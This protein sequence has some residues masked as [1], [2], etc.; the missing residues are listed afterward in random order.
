MTI[1]P[2]TEL[3]G[4]TGVI[5]QGNAKPA[6]KTD[7]KEAFSNATDSIAPVAGSQMIRTEGTG[8]TGKDSDTAKNMMKDTAQN[9]REIRESA[10]ADKADD[11][12][13]G[14]AAVNDQAGE[15]TSVSAEKKA[16]PKQEEALE[17]TA[18]KLIKEA[19]KVLGVSEDELAQLLSELGLTASALLEPSN[20]NLLVANAMGDGDMMSLVTDGALSDAVKQLNELVGNAVAELQEIVPGLDEADLKDL[21]TEALDTVDVARENAESSVSAAVVTEE[22]GDVSR[23]KN[24]TLPK[25]TFLQEE[26]VVQDQGNAIRTEAV[27]KENVSDDHGVMQNASGDDKNDKDQFGDEVRGHESFAEQVRPEGQ[28]VTTEAEAV[29]PETPQTYVTDPQ[30]LL[31]QVQGQLRT[32]VTADVTSIDMTLHPASLGNVA[33]RIASQNGQ[34]TAQFTAQNESVKEVLEG[35]IMILK[36]NLEQQGV[37]VEAVEVTVASHAFEQNLEQGND[38]ES[39]ASEKEREKLRRAT[40]KINLGNSAGEGVEGLED[41]DEV[42]VEMM[43]ADGQ[44]LNYRV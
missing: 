29:R 7:F 30:E 38:G 44:Q 12:R 17:K 32:R 27:S 35:Q 25:E 18:D 23:V 31:D 11:P 43:Q 1:A 19:A 8:A 37:K 9:T 10:A 22:L 2:I 33:L 36:Q 26:P 40:H 20:I 14:D 41:A 39:E 15:R 28:Q 21:F 5:S 6:P 34:V 16:D 3:G 13:T 4:I 42:T 24:D